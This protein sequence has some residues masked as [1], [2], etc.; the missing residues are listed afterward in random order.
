M[1]NCNVCGSETDAYC[2]GCSLYVC[3]E[4]Y[5]RPYAGRNIVLC[6]DCWRDRDRVLARIEEERAQGA[7]GGGGC[8]VVTA[9]FGSPLSREVQYLRSFRS[10]VFLKTCLGK[11]SLN[12][13]ESIYYSFSPRVASYLRDYPMVKDIVKSEVVVPFL[14]SLSALKRLS[15][16][17]PNRGSRVCVVALLSF[18]N[19]TLGLVFW[20]VISSLRRKHRLQ[21]RSIQQMSSHRTHA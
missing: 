16:S 20:R 17:F 6:Q 13:L 14:E 18:V 3:H 12:V 19:M 10:E 4:H 2:D 11:S 9:C 15:E 8:L 7:Q 1:G 21:R 5:Y